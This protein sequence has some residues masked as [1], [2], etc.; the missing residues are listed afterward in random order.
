MK[1]LLKLYKSSHGH[2]LNVNNQ[3]YKF[4]ASAQNFED[5]KIY[6]GSEV[7]F[8]CKIDL[9]PNKFITNYQI[10]NIYLISGIQ[11]SYLIKNYS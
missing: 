3:R 7:F 11:S 4:V 10:K 9:V 5:I 1:Q 2:R 8:F 6:I